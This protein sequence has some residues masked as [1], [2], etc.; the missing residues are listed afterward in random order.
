MSG[1][2]NI[3]NQLQSDICFIKNSKGLTGP[4]GPTGPR[5]NIGATGPM[6]PSNIPSD[7]LSKLQNATSQISFTLGPN[8]SRFIG[9]GFYYYDTNADLVNGYFITAAHCA[10]QITNNIYYKT[11]AAYIQN[12][13]TTKWITVNVN[14]IYV[15]GVAD[16]ALIRTGIDFTNYPQYCLKLNTGIVNAGDECYVVGN[17]GGI[18]EDSISS[19]CVRDPNYCEPNGFQITNSIF[20]NAPGIGGN[21]GG[22]IVN[23]NGDVIGIYTFGRTNQ[24]CYGG[25]SNQSVLA[26]TLPVLKQNTDNK[27]KLYLGLDWFITNPFSINLFYPSQTTFDTTGVVIYD[28]NPLSPFFGILNVDNLLLKCVVNNTTIEFGNKNN[29]RTPGV[30]L[31]Y[32]VGTTIT[33]HYKKLNDNTVY[34]TNVQLN[35]TY[36]DVPNTLD[37]PLQTGYSQ[38]DESRK[39]IVKSNQNDEKFLKSIKSMKLKH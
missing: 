8:N 35:K 9:S 16:I 31:Y 3:I 30:L 34:T 33:I 15:D 12:P 23:K 7:I 36:A 22:P 18:D 20:I 21:S 14:N 26:S 39:N 32:P 29:Q 28:I 25:G 13:I 19:G 11:T 24:E 4:S 5:G 27:S 1:C 37:G 17:P 38:N 6:G 10:I 2:S